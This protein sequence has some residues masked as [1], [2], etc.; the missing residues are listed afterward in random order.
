[1]KEKKLEKTKKLPQRKFL[2]I[3]KQK[4]HCKTYKNET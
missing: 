2:K 3:L 4:H 1:M